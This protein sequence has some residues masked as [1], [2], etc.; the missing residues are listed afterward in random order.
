MRALLQSTETGR[1]LARD[2][3]SGCAVWVRSLRDALSSGVIYDEEHLSQLIED[4][5]DF[6]GFSVVDLDT[7]DL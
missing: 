7:F 3:D 6:G 4:H 5:C 2:T 1:F